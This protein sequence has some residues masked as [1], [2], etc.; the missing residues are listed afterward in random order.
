MWHFEMTDSQTINKIC[1]LKLFSSFKIAI[2]MY[3]IRL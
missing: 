3:P 1:N 2:Q